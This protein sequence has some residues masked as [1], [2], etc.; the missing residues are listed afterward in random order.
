MIYIRIYVCVVYGIE[1]LFVE[2]V[3]F[4][5]FFYIVTKMKLYREL[6]RCS[7]IPL[8]SGSLII[9]RSNSKTSIRMCARFCYPTIE[10]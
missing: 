6:F 2:F 8:S 9:S 5:L 4:S 7:T 1:L 10:L 3:E